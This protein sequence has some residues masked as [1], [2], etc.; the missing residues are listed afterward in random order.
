MGVQNK[1]FGAVFADGLI[2]SLDSSVAQTTFPTT[3]KVWVGKNN[4]VVICTRLF[5]KASVSFWCMCHHLKPNGDQHQF[6]PNNIHMLSREI[7]TRINQMITKEKL[8]WTFIRLSQF[9]SEEL[10]EYQ[11]GE[12]A[13][14]C[15]GLKG[16]TGVVAWKV[17][18]PCLVACV[19]PS[20][21]II[22]YHFIDYLVARVFVIAHT[23][24]GHYVKLMNMIFAAI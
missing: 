14:G 18:F 24:I 22:S 23:L 13:C 2:Q 1:D 3:I 15:W 12:F 17:Y 10:C 21:H 11:S 8:L 20:T 6:S 7:I 9:I 19:L 16:L 5:S 4:T